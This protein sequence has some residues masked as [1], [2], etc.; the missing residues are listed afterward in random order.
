MALEKLVL[1][2]GHLH[3]LG[4]GAVQILWTIW[5]RQGLA[6]TPKINTHMSSVLCSIGLWQALCQYLVGSSKF[7]CAVQI[8]R[9]T[10]LRSMANKMAYHDKAKFAT[11]DA[12]LAGRLHTWLPGASPP[13]LL[14]S[15]IRRLLHSTL[16][17][18]APDSPCH[19]GTREACDCGGGLHM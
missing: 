19:R 10:W 16:P 7:E 3:S 8:L 4:F 14:N 15:S 18:I 2:L 17:C 5:L 9:T 1:V 13:A 6:F 11:V 12:M